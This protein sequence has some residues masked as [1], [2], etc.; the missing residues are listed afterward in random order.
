MRL[1]GS[2]TLLVHVAG[3]NRG[4]RSGLPSSLQQIVSGF[5]ISG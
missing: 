3:H 5:G 1:D 2:A 4:S